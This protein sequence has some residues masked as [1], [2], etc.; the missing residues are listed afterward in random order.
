MC[1][2]QHLQLRTGKTCFFGFGF[3]SKSLVI[4]GAA[5]AGGGES[6]GSAGSPL[7]SLKFTPQSQPAQAAE[8]TASVLP[9]GE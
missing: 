9:E 4:G 6:R 3:N 5:G 7:V 2:L 1:S 8:G